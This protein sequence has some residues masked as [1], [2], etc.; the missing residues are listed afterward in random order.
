MDEKIAFGLVV[1]GGQSHRMGKDKALMR[2]HGIPQY[3]W[4]AN[5]L[6]VFC[7][8]I[9]IAGKDRKF[10]NYHCLEDN[11]EF[12][13]I[14]PLAAL[15][16]YFERHEEAV[17]VMGI[18]YPS[19]TE[20]DLNH[21]LSNRDKSKQATI[22]EHPETGI[23]EPLLGLYEPGMAKILRDGFKKGEHSIQRLLLAHDIKKVVPL[24]SSRLKSFDFPT[25]YELFFQ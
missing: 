21:L 6:S 5:M 9:L 8:K 10:E 13:S 11:P 12:G 14:G 23:L 15:L 19:I 22:F 7:H 2:Y 3:Q 16:S 17:L 25:D 4:T 18:D 20:A 24:D 1:A